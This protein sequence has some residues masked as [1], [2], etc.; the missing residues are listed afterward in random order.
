MNFRVCTCFLGL[1]GTTALADETLYVR[2]RDT[3][4]RRDPK[5]SSITVLKLQEG[6]EVTWLGSEVK[7]NGMVKVS[8]KRKEGFIARDDLTPSK[9]ETEL[10]SDGKLISGPSFVHSGFQGGPPPVPKGDEQRSAQLSRVEGL[11]ARVTDK[12]LKD[13]ATAAK[14]VAK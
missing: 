13:H 4:L 14:L 11:S 8:V 12:D 1:L 7:G 10:T 5:P 3:N 6:T 9:P 2:S